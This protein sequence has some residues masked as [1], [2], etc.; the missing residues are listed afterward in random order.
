MGGGLLLLYC[1]ES[2]RGGGGQ[3]SW[4]KTIGRAKWGT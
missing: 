1:R 3:K 4:K 2:T